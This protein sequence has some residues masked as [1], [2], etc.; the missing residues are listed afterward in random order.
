[1]DNYKTK[2]VKELKDFMASNKKEP[3][4]T[5]II[6]IIS[7][8]DHLYDFVERAGLVPARWMH[9]HFLTEFE[10]VPIGEDRVFVKRGY[11]YM[12]FHVASWESMQPAIT[13]FMEEIPEAEHKHVDFI[14]TLPMFTSLNMNIPRIVMVQY[15]DTI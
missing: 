5:P 6:K 2:R 14:T 8:I 9:D 4:N 3:C 10:I 15:T 1:M 11:P 12:Q 13:F 7:N